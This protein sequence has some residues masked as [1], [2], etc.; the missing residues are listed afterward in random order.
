[1]FTHPG[2]KLNFM[3][4]ELA[5][6][7]E[8]DEKVDLDWEALLS[9]VHAGFQTY[10]RRL[11]DVY[12]KNPALWEN[13]YERSSFRWISKAEG[14]DAVLAFTRSAGGRDL[15]AILN[16]SD[17]EVSFATDLA[18]QASLVLDTHDKDSIDRSCDG[19]LLMPY[20]GMLFELG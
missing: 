8:W 7:R 20:E 19:I 17:Q 16:F 6:T 12:M 4:N 1:M 5:R 3:G 18:D 15:L 11:N 9:P 13:D 10:F 2:K 14:G